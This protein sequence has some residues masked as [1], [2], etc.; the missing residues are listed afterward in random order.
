VAYAGVS[1]FAFAGT[2]LVAGALGA[3]RLVPVLG[4]LVICALLVP[5]L[6]VALGPG[7]RACDFLLGEYACRGAFGIGALLCVAIGVFGLRHALASRE[8]AGPSTPGKP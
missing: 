1:A 7:A 3:R 2:S 5:A 8:S 4:V 6:W